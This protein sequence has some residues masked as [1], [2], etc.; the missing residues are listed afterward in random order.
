METGG[1]LKK[2]CFSVFYLICQEPEDLED[3]LLEIHP[4]LSALPTPKEVVTT[5]LQN[6]QKT[7]S[8]YKALAGSVLIIF[9][10]K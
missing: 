2:K 3:D 10:E 8:P 4:S 1:W 9:Y 5:P 6:K 7:R